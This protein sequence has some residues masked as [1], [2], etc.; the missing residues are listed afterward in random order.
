MRLGKIP[1]NVLKR[2][3]LKQ[4]KNKR[5]EVI[6]GAGVGEDCAIF[7]FDKENCAVSMAP[8]MFEKS[9]SPEYAIHKAV[10]NLAA[11]GAFPV[12]VMLTVLLPETISEAELKKMMTEAEE[13]CRNL[14]IQLTGGHTEISNA[15]T[16]PVFIAAGIGKT[17]KGKEIHTKGA[18]PGQ[19]LVIT[20]WIGLEGTV[21]LAK[22]RK[23][24]LLLKYPL[25]LV[26]EAEDFAQYLSV[27]PEA[28][29]AVQSGAFVMHDASEG[30]IFGA[31]WEL[32]EN[33]GVGL[34]I[35][36]KKLPVKQETIEI[37][38]Y[39]DLN[40]Y[41]LISGG[42]L[43]IVTDHGT[44]L[45]RTL[46]KQNIPA[47]VAGK[48]TD[49]HDRVVIKDGE[50]RFLELPKPDEIYRVKGKGVIGE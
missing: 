25:H 15:V 38:E 5:D 27:V 16:R 19:E 36:F 22:E 3:V 18:I 50:R 37:C 44:D 13:T 45:V 34:E 21:I 41:E 26:E 2:S 33:S 6:N 39:F 23:E 42:C 8:S 9:G 35:D 31:L 49:N 29:A 17:Q 43:L 24:E 30:G 28:A 11:G 48:I 14:G 4:M 40:P 46:E 32:A 20:K 1:E 12:G 7:S 47:V 10:N